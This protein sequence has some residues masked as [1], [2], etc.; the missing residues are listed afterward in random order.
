MES[1]GWGCS[2]RLERN[3]RIKQVS[4]L[5]RTHY[6]KCTQ[7]KGSWKRMRRN[8]QKSRKESEKATVFEVSQSIY[9]GH[10]R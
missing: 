5:W 4:E 2:Q 6:L 10:V 3:E 1:D 9:R 8:A 7:K